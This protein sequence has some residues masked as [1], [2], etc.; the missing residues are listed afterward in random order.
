[1]QQL[2]RFLSCISFQGYRGMQGGVGD[3]GPVGAPVK[4]T[5]HSCSSTRQYVRYPP[6]P[7]HPQVSMLHSF[8]LLVPGSGICLIVDI[9]I[10]QSHD[11]DGVT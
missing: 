10:G 3:Q 4:L 8:M 11:A 1:M 7:L 5:C 9:D 2:E 6:P